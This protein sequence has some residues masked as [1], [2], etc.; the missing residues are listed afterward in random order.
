[1]NCGAT[2]TRCKS[3]RKID[4]RPSQELIESFVSWAFLVVQRTRS[5]L[6]KKTHLQGSLWIYGTKIKVQ[7]ASFAPLGGAKTNNAQLLQQAIDVHVLLTLCARFLL[8]QC[9][10]AQTHIALENDPSAFSCGI[11]YRVWLAVSAHKL[12]MKTSPISNLLSATLK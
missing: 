4:C 9:C 10:P 2:I 8:T 1:M 11:K 12:G 3:Q 7:W 6:N 5:R